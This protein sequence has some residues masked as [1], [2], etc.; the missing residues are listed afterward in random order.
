MRHMLTDGFNETANVVAS[1][2]LI[3]VRHILI[4]CGKCVQKIWIPGYHWVTFRNSTR[5]IIVIKVNYHSLIFPNTSTCLDEKELWLA[6][7]RF[8]DAEHIIK[9]LN[10]YRVTVRT[11]HLTTSAIAHKPQHKTIIST[12]ILVNN[13]TKFVHELLFWQVL[14][15]SYWKIESSKQRFNLTNIFFRPVT[16]WLFSMFIMMGKG[17]VINDQ[18]YSSWASCHVVNEVCTRVITRTDN[19][20]T[21]EKG[22]INI[23]P[24]SIP[25]LNLN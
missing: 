2:I 3:P 23:S 1:F 12:V 8:A 6:A 10:S 20:A 11:E 16:S 25:D 4:D 5:R 22:K 19:C 21:K 14:L 18:R 17:R 7:K 24:L 9:S 13:I 15:C